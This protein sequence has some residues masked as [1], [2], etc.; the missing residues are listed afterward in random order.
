MS[1]TPTW[2]TTA[3][4]INS[5]G[6]FTAPAS[7]TNATITA[8]S[9]A[10]KGTASVVVASQNS[11]QNSAL[12][13]L[14]TTLVADGSLNRD[15]VIQVLRSTGTDGTVDGTELGDLRYIVANAVTYSMPGYVQVLASNIVNSN[16]ANA[17]YQGTTAGNLT[18]GSSSTLLTK[19]VDKWFYGA[20]LPTISTSG[21]SYRAATGP[22]FVNGTPS[23]NDQKQGA[24]GD[25]YFI[26]TLGAL[27][28]R[29]PSAV[30]NMF[31]DNGDGTFTVRFYTGN[32]S[33][34]T[35]ADGSI[36]DGFAS[37]TGTA[38]YVTVNRQLPSYSN[39]TFAYSNAGYSI[40]SSSAAIW[41]AL[42]EK[43]Y[44]QWNETGKSGRTAANTYASIEGGWMGTVNAQV[45]GVNASSYILANT[46]AQPLINAL[47]AGKGGNDWHQ[48]IS[49]QWPGRRPCLFGHG[50]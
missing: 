41:I 48:V 36:S 27:A 37:G 34:F 14:V 26:S 24:L 10:I 46:T 49:R 1:V 23:F 15:D 7:T 39:N 38:D 12:A 13:N 50:L 29:N 47:S 43:A 19:L 20:D 40:T 31:I 2:T 3:G 33:M 45:L 25:C 18:A 42:A 9:G 4:T 22:L 16:T 5:S 17:R 28:G 32:Y 8:T 21:V 44:A 11:I 35:T 30:S 6:L